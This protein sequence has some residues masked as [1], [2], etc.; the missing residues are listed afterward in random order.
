[1]AVTD[2]ITLIA[3]DVFA[4]VKVF[5][6]RLVVVSAFAEYKLFKERLE[7]FAIDTTLRT[8]TFAVVAVRF[9]VKDARFEMDTTFRVPTLATPAVRFVVKDARFAIDTTFRG[10]TL[11]KE[12]ITELAVRLVFKEFRFEIVMT[13]RVATFRVEIEITEGKSALT[14]AR[15]KGAP[16]DPMDGPA[17]TWF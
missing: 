3:D 8:P 15:K 7:R 13:F 11:A 1:V 17:K 9:V 2:P 4:N 16:A 10:P 12:G 6:N 5:A 14:R